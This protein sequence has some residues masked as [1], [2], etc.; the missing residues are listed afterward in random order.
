MNTLGTIAFSVKKSLEDK[1]YKLLLV[2]VSLVVFFLFVLIPTISIPGNTF[3]YQLSLFSFLDLTIT[4]SLSILY[5]VFVVMQVYSMRHKKQIS[6]IGATVVGGA[7]TLLAGVA[8]ASFCASCLA[9]LFAIFGVGFGGVLFLLEYRF[10]FVI[11][12]AL[13]MLIAIYLTSLKIQEDSN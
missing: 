7:G 1:K 10:Y 11:V 6:D 3:L 9:P 13:L 4:I 2:F 12:I 8:G 5:A